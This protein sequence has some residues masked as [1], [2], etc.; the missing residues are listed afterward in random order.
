MQEPAGEV[1]GH[2][3]GQLGAAERRGDS[4]GSCWAPVRDPDLLAFPVPP[5]ARQRQSHPSPQSKV[6]GLDTERARQELPCAKQGM[7]PIPG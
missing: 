3:H 1:S 2:W 7:P 4:L 6:L 5:S